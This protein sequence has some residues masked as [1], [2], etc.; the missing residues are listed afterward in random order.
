MSNG[1]RKRV[2]GHCV[3]VFG[4][5]AGLAGCG[6]S[7]A[8]QSQTE[9]T[10]LDDSGN[11]RQVDTT[12]TGQPSLSPGAGGVAPR[13]YPA[14]P[15]DPRLHQ[16]FAE[17]VR[18]GEDPPASSLLPPDQTVAGKT[19]Y[20]IL[21]DIRSQWDNIHFTND[22]GKPIDYKAIVHTDHGDIEIK[23]LPEIAPN[24][25]RN[26]IALARAGYYDE[27]FFDRTGHEE[28]TLE[29]GEK[30]VLDQIQA[31]CPRGSGELGHGHIGYWLKPEFTDKVSHEEGT[32]GA[33]RAEEEDSAACKFYITL[34]RAPVLDQ[35]YTIFGK[36]TRGLDI[37]R[38]IYEEPSVSSDQ[39]QVGYRRPE[40]PVKI[41]KVV[42]EQRERE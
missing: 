40:K 31:G 13:T 35:Y 6:K 38:K 21:M 8:P 7:P 5:L 28:A 1:A 4:L 34:T 10:Q 14:A 41:K 36:V 9:S 22:Q 19:V 30:V 42:I 37:V 3:I 18:K 16:P 15:R 39:G 33:C 17:A 26:F 2:C 23:L 32:V 25:V 27:L 12:N 11:A 24:H 20:T 29:S